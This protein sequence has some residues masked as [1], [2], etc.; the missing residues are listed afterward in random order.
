MPQGLKP[1]LSA[2]F[3]LRGCILPNLKQKTFQIELTEGVASLSSKNILIRF[4]LATIVLIVFLFAACSSRY[5]VKP[6]EYAEFKGEV[7]QHVRLVE[8]D[9]IQIYRILT[10]EKTFGELCPEGTV[11]TYESPVPYEEGLLVKTRIDHLFQLEWF[12]RV[13]KITPDHSIRLRFLDGFFSDGKEIWE[14]EEIGSSTRV[15]HTIIF[16]PDGFFK[17]MAWL[18]KVRKRHDEMVEAFLD[19]LNAVVSSPE[20]QEARL[21]WSYIP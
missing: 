8:A 16:Q 3:L 10:C 18:L 13:E 4:R 9:R 19:N 21:G 6:P 17:K 5:T 14:L 7:N 11:V 2:S 1:K 20:I 15:S 12:S